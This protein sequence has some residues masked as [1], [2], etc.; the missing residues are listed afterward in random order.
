LLPDARIT[1]TPS[2]IPTLNP[3]TSRSISIAVEIPSCTGGGHFEAT[4]D[5][6]VGT[7]LAASV[8][9]GFD[10]V[11]PEDV[12]V[13]S[14]S[15]VSGPSQIR[16]GDVVTY[17]V[18]VLGASGTAIRE[19]CLH[20]TVVPSS[21]GFVTSEGAFV[22]YV[23]SSAFVVV[24]ADSEGDSV[25]V[26]VTARALSGSFSAV[27]QGVQ[28]DTGTWGTR[29]GGFGNTLYTWD[30]S[31]RTAPVMADSLFIDA[32]VV[33]DVK[34]RS[35]GALA[36]ITHEASN[37][38]QNGIT[39]VDLADP[40]SPEVVSRFTS[41]LE[42]G[43]HNAWVEGDFVYLVV[44]NAIPSA[45]LRVLDISNPAAPMT[46]ANFYAGSSFLHDVYVRDGLAFLS[47]WDAGLVIL[48]VGNGL[49]GG[50]PG[51]PVEVSRVPTAGGQ[52]HNAW[53]W[54]Q[55]GYVFVG[56]EDF[57]TPGIMHVVDVSDLRTPREVA[58]FRV[59]GATPHNFWLDE[60]RAVL[61]LAWYENGIRAVD[62]SGRLL[63]ELDRQGREITSSVYAG[64]VGGCVSD[65]ST[66]TCTWA[67]QLQDGF[68]YVA[69]M[70]TG[71]W[72]LQPQF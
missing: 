45:G 71:L 65:F 10:A 58:T 57:S 48:D 61:Y 36:V 55:A 26:N 64:P 60:D 54:P 37:D 59:P 35:D 14:L 42:T 47:H 23:P 38:Q 46:V 21:A 52:T 56:E 18:D 43:V 2:E 27:G 34:I 67:P 3:G 44:D 7:M 70:N 69:D 20:W 62:V 53:Y 29:S 49:A 19:V 39:L 51:T 40:L 16:Q 22:G 9:L 32:R 28:T 8:G 31:D 12:D 41:S 24:R 33:N 15:V 72:V 1:I 13:Q 30:I 68:L 50:S 17:E 66:A 11:N 5:A 25:E 63:G 6:V 4:I